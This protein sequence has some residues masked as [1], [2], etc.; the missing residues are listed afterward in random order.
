MPNSDSA[1]KDGTENQALDFD[2]PMLLGDT[3]V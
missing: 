3:M 2:I 1:G